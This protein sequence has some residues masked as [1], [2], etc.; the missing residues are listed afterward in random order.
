MCTVPL[1]QPYG[2]T[3]PVTQVV[4]FCSTS[5]ATPDCSDIE[6][7]GRMKR[8]NPLDAFV[9]H[10]SPNRESLVDAS[11][12]ASDYRTGE[13]L[14]SFLISLFYSAVNVHNVT[15]LEVRNLVLETITFDGIQYFSFH[16]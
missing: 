12:L 8:E 10:D 14:R 16:R 4:E 6:H 13:N 7:V 2:F 1:G 5:F 9:I 15:Y 11:S 3:R